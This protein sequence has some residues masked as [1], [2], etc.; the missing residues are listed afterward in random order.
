MG[1]TIKSGYNY[2]GIKMK[3]IKKKKPR[4]NRH[5]N[6]DDFMYEDDTDYYHRN[7]DNIE[8]QNED[9]HIGNI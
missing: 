2:D 9:Y 3:T 4:K 1:K 6:V 5:I 7:L 8:Y